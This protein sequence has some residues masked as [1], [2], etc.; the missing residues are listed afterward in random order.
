M[1]RAPIG[2]TEPD[3]G[4]IATRPA[5]APVARPTAV[6]LPLVNHSTNIQLA[7]AVA[8]AAAAGQQTG[9][10]DRVQQRPQRQCAVVRENQAA[11]LQCGPGLTISRVVFA[12][13]GSPTGGCGG[14][15]RGDSLQLSPSCHAEEARS[16]YAY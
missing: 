1:S 5:T 11:A 8:V 9:G 15:G 14:D 7:A 13:Y 6:G 2:P 12:S 4:V 10:D 16:E 3:A